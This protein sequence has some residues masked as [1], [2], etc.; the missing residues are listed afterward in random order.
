MII[1]LAFLSLLMFF[2][3]ISIAIDNSIDPF[4]QLENQ[5]HEYQ[6]RAEKLR[7]ELE[8]M[9][10]ERLKNDAEYERMRAESLRSQAELDRLNAE[11]ERSKSELP[12]LLEMLEENRKEREKEEAVQKAQAAKDEIENR[13]LQ[14]EIR[15]QNQLFLG[16]MM[17]I[18]TVFLWNVVKTYRR[19]KLMK[20]FEKFGV[21]T[22]V[23]SVL[24][25]LLVLMISDQWVANFDFIQNLMT[26]LR[27][28]LFNTQENCSEWQDCETLIDFPT[29][30]AVLTFLAFASYGF[31]TYVGITP[32][33]KW[34]K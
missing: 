12:S 14:S 18:V 3:C 19:E 15:H 10:V 26:T 16:V 4:Q 32:P 22:I 23:V 31:T 30:Y 24:L 8:K 13:L 27:V 6:L 7:L 1:K 17:F 11:H 9:E 28:K 20:D 29:K 25:I 33:F 34:K 2:P 21:I 5:N